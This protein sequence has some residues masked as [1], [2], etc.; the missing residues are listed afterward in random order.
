MNTHPTDLINILLSCCGLS[1]LKLAHRSRP[2]G[3]PLAQFWTAYDSTLSM[4][5]YL[6]LLEDDAAFKTRQIPATHLDSINGEVLLDDVTRSSSH[7]FRSLVLELLY[8]KLDDF[9]QAFSPASQSGTR[10]GADGLVQLS[11]DRLRS[12]LTCLVSSTIMLPYLQNL[13]TRIATDINAVLDDLWA[14][15]IQMTLDASESLEALQV[16]LLSV[17]PYIPPLETTRVERFCRIHTHLIRLCALLSNLINDIQARHLSQQDPD[18]MEVDAFGSQNSKVQSS[19]TSVHS[20]RDKVAMDMSSEAFFESTKM[21]LHLLAQYSKNPESIGLVPDLVVDNMLALTDDKFLLCG[22]FLQELLKSDFGNVI[23]YA[24]DIIEQIGG[25][26]KQHGFSTCEAVWCICIDVLASLA[27]IWSMEGGDRDLTSPFIDLYNFLTKTAWPTNILSPQA[28]SSLISLLY[29]LMEIN[30]QIHLDKS[31]KVDPPQKT[32]LSILLESRLALKFYIGSR[33]TEFFELHAVNAHDVVFIEILHALPNDADNIEGIAFRISILA[34]LGCSCPT[35][36]RRCVY[37]MLEV[38]GKIAD[39]EQYAAYGM[40]MVA[41][42]RSLSSPKELF[43]LFAPQLLY[44]WL[45]EP[46][47]KDSTGQ[48]E[49]NSIE[50]IPYSIFDFN[51]L[52]ELLTYAQTEAAAITIMHSHVAVQERAFDSLATRLQLPAG[53]II[54]NGFSK[55]LAY[56]IGYICEGGDNSGAA[57]ARVR[58]ILGKEA[59]YSCLYDN[60]VDIVGLF[61]VLADQESLVEN[62]WRRIEG[63]TKAAETMEA[64]KKCGHSATQLPPNQ[65]PCFKAKRLPQ[66]IA[67]LTSKTRYDAQTL[68][69]P[70]LVASVARRLLNI[71]HPALG[72]HHA[73]AVV[74]KIRVLIS[75]AGPS[76]THRYPLEMLLRSMMPFIS[77]PECADDAIGICQWL[78][79]N[80][81]SHLAKVPSFLAGYAL[82]TLASLRMFLESSQSSTTQES[83]FKS[84]IGKAQQ[85]H[86]SFVGRLEEY[87]SRYFK[88]DKQREAFKAIV[89]SASNIRSSG[90]SETQTP[91]SKLLLEILKDAEQEDRLLNDSARDIALRMLCGDFRVSDSPRNDI[92]QSDQDACTHGPMVWKSCQ[93]VDSSNEYFT[94]AGR[95]VGRSFAASGDVPHEVLRESLLSTYFKTAMQNGDSVHGLLRLLSNLTM[96]DDSSYAGFAESAVRMIV[97]LAAA[98]EDQDLM[99]DCRQSMPET[100]YESSNWAPYLTPMTDQGQGGYITGQD[101]LEQLEIQSPSWAKHLALML[102]VSAQENVI[103]SSLSSILTHV[104]GFAE[105]ALPYIVHSVLL[106]EFDSK[107]VVRQNLL[108]AAKEWLTSTA[109]EATGNI[110]LMMNV[111]LYLRSRPYPNETSINDRARW[112]DLENSIMA[113]AA[114]RCGMFKVALMFAELAT[115]EASRT[116]RRSSASRETNDPSDL[117][118]SIFENIDDPDAYYGL[119]RTASLS[120]VLARLEYENEGSKSL[121][122]RGAQYDSHIRNRDLASEQDEQSL[123]KI[124]SGLGLAGLSDSLLQAQ[125][126]HDN[127]LISLDSTFTTARRLEKWNL[128]AP[129]AIENPSA[130]SYRA[131]QSIYKAFELAPAK[132]AI[133]DGLAGTM[134]RLVSKSLKGSELRQHLATLA[135][136]SELDDVLGVS[137]SGELERIFADFEARSKWMMSARYVNCALPVCC[138]F[139]N[140]LLGMTMSAKYCLTVRQL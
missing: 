97:S 80:G 69:T 85:F 140:I 83:Q 138:I 39:T 87:D 126:H 32:L 121:A 36:L 12:L 45:N 24:A 74:R 58:K 114:A 62:A 29:R 116:S 53:E 28:Q 3:G 65:Q 47:G 99:K 92:L 37:H 108:A 117:L 1:A 81:A 123:V 100:L 41:A 48:I 90:N 96:S 110:K 18:A 91:E 98:H 75:L 15:C 86:A 33:A 78:I 34:Q 4:T 105:Q 68:W 122:F 27:P 63:L 89:L 134:R 5:R 14:K 95:V 46:L 112:L 72:P 31:A 125:Q 51:S 82:S 42:A 64:I 8:P 71:I 135:A 113:E 10:R 106:E 2:V 111:V 43:R 76:A 94:W 102:I 104:D 19:S 88:S 115:S 54:K 103:L 7:N 118:L 44:T 30:S 56:S 9:C 136:L 133:R 129:P 50:D 139:S 13:E 127:S 57:E 130:T 66:Q 84:T 40:K 132:L 55:I 77:E 67:Y 25:I 35:L 61:F 23:N 128:P 119:E 22:D 17:A 101:G 109:P 120:N 124:L 38:P 137:D 26:L 49:R 70:A 59:F 21:R 131:Y 16:I 73:L 52:E 20:P 11:T 6:L 107:R 79:T 60:F 93:A